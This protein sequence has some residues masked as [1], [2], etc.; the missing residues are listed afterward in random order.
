M[1][2]KVEPEKTGKR[3]QTLLPIGEKESLVCVCQL[4]L[5]KFVF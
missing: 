3:K 4:A 1:K 2:S 5:F